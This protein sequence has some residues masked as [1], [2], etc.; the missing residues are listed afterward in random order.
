MKNHVIA[1][2]RMEKYNLNVKTPICG[3]YLSSIQIDL[4]SIIQ[5]DSIEDLIDFIKNCDQ[6]NHVKG[7]LESI[8]G[9][10]LESAKRSVFKSYQDTMVFHD[11]SKTEARLKRL[12]YLGLSTEQ[13]ALEVIE[14]IRLN[15]K[16]LLEL[17]HHFIAEERDQAKSEDLYEEMTLLNK[18][19]SIF[20]SFL[21]GSGKIY[22]VVNKLEFDKDRK[23]DFYHAKRDLDFATKNGKKVRYHSLLVNEDYGLFTGKT[24]EAI[25][26]IIKDYVKASIDFINN[27]NEEYHTIIDVDLFNEIVS[28]EKDA[29]G[30][31]YNI[32]EQKY[33]IS[34][35]ELLECFDYALQNKKEG[36]RYLYNEPF[37]EDEERRKKVLETLTIIDRLRPGLI[38]TLGSQ[39]HIT[40]TQDLDSIKR[41]YKDFKDLQ[42]KTGKEIQITEFDMSLGKNDIPRVFGQHSDIT[43]EQVYEIKKKKISE[44]SDI[45]NSSGIKL[46]G[47]SY[48]SLTDGTDCNL[49]R[50]RSHLLKEHKINNINQIPTACGGLIP[51]HKRL[52][53]SQQLDQMLSSSSTKDNQIQASEVK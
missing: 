36:I 1:G 44:I 23:F 12:E 27:Y 5:C 17:N 14:G 15:S 38:D 19:L 21:I 46:S 3:G 24:K 11:K 51:T 22:N 31:Y 41:C 47:V 2:D 30:N 16:E 43:L 10:D 49:E 20:N 37:L 42:D 53:K 32:W 33:G 6:I 4:L 7:I 26:N 48:W 45:I 29:E 25:L 40:I 39:M 50:V 13:E 18:E 35:Q 52:M 8:N 9:L 28:F 34:L